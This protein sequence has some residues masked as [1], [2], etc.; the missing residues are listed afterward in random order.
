VDVGCKKGLCHKHDFSLLQ[1]DLED[2]KHMG[3]NYV[4]GF[5]ICLPSANVHRRK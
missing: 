3:I 1:L 5:H 4:Q 2:L